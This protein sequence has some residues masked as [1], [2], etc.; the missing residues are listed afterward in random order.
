MN[1]PT[2]TP[3]EELSILFG[4][5]CDGLHQEARA[6]RM[7]KLTIG[8]SGVDLGVSL[9]QA[10]E[11]EVASSLYFHLRSIGFFVQM[12]SYFATGN[13]R[14]RPDFRI[15]LPVTRTYL[16]LELKLVAW[17]RGWRFYGKP[18]LEDI[19]KLAQETDPQNLPNGLA[20][21]GFDN[22]D[23]HERLEQK[24]QKLSE[25]I[26]QQ[27]PSY[28]RVGLQ[29]VDLQGLD[30][31]TSCAMVGLWVRKCPTQPAD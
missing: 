17:G 25:D 2:N 11:T 19:G 22:P 31:R 28:Q 30:A 3:D 8:A 4:A 20:M 6:R 23:A 13:Q 16:Y 27:H 5:F 18:A 21:I 14:R 12:E 26:T 1:M 24:C 29:S 7:A 15:W 10:R 9:T